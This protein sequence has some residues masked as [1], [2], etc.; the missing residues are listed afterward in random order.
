MKEKQGVEEVQ[1]LLALAKE[2]DDVQRGVLVLAV[3]EGLNPETQQVVAH[4]VSNL[5]ATTQHGPTLSNKIA[6]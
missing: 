6:Q 5:W 3:F 2:L 1:A 4:K